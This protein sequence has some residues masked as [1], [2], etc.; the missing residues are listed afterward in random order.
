MRGW[1]SVSQW[2]VAAVLVAS[3]AGEPASAVGC[4]MCD[5]SLSCAG[6]DQG[7]KFCLQGPLSCT[8]ALPCSFGPRR[9]P[10]SGESL[11]AWSLFEIEGASATT[12]VEL[13]AGPL[14][15]GEMMRSARAHG[16]GPLADATLAFGEGL[17][18][19]LSDA[20][21]E[22]FAVRRTA[23]AGGVHLEVLAVQGDQPGRV[24][25]DATLGAR[26][27]LRVPIRAGGRDRLLVLQAEDVPPGLAQA[28]I[29]RLRASLR[30]AAKT[31]AERSEPLFKTRA[32]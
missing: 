3:L 31:Q 6:A 16:R 26:D 4:F 7:G 17:A 32:F 13:D 23:Q 5:P 9:A 12:G 28:T 2:G 18:V 29:A 27:R 25:A 1:K 10:D 30:E 22:G 11:T 20:A 14:S 21:G 15:V 19:I 8:L 24:L